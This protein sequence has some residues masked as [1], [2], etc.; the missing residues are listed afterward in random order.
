[1]LVFPDKRNC[2][3]QGWDNPDSSVP[4]FITLDFW[5]RKSWRLSGNFGDFWG[6]LKVFERLFVVLKAP[7][8][9]WKHLKA[10]L[11]APERTWMHTWTRTW[12]HL[13]APESIWKPTWKLT[14]VWNMCEIIWA[15]R[16]S[17]TWKRTWKHTW[18]HLNAPKSTP[19]AP[20]STW[21][22]KT[23]CTWK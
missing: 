11:N 1:M 5:Y 18:K 19:I 23:F 21:K 17:F 9:I 10:H 4:Q 2:W 20:E 8:S 3:L 6:F 7:E 15:E 13:K 14:L 12:K 16:T 22:F